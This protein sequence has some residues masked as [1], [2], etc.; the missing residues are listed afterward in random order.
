MIFGNDDEEVNA[1]LENEHME[2]ID[3]VK[4][5]TRSQLFGCFDPG[6]STMCEDS[7]DI[8][9]ELGVTRRNVADI[10]EITID[11]H[12]DF[13]AFKRTV[14]SLNTEQKYSIYYTYIIS[15]FALSEDI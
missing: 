14:Q 3:I 12:S 5:V 7:Y 10:V 13:T 6:S 1:N 4:G 8:S 11:T 2:S 15:C 9:L